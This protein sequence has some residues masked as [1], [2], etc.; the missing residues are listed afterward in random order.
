MSEQDRVFRCDLGGFRS[1]PKTTQQGFLKLTGNLTRTGVLKYR[2]RDG[3][4]VR[5]LRHPDD[6]FHEDSVRSLEDAPVTDMHPQG[7]VTADNAKN[8]ALG[9]VKAVAPAAQFLTGEIVVQDASLIALVKSGERRELSPGYTCTLEWGAGEY[10]GEKYD[11]RQRSIVYNHLALGPSGWGRSG[12]EVS[13]HMDSA[14]TELGLFEETEIMTVKKDNETN[15]TPAQEPTEA[16]TQAT[17]AAIAEAPKEEEPKEE[18][19]EAEDTAKTQ[20]IEAAAEQKTDDSKLATLETENAQLRAKL[21]AANEMLKPE[22]FRAAV[23]KRVV[24]EQNAKKVLGADFKMDSLSD[25]EIFAAALKARG[26]A[27]EGKSEAYVEARFD[28]ILETSGIHNIR[29]VRADAAAPVSRKLDPRE[30]LIA[31]QNKR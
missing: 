27:T 24:V 30:A 28:A 17:V 21:D 9:H 18:A 15:A 12:P 7:L 1:K 22:H 23:A 19:P 20:T 5:E 8:S 14:A 29:Q 11:A 13:I 2:T 10:N 16:E 26:I 3:N 31:S 6:V 4:V 25:Q